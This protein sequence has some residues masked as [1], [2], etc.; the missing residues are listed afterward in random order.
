MSVSDRIQ[1][2]SPAKLELLRQRL[3]Q[4]KGAAAQEQIIPRRSDPQ[5]LVPLSFAQQRL[6]FLDGLNPESA[7]YNMP[8]AI[9]LRGELNV[10]ALERS[11]N[12]LLRRHE[13]LRTS[14]SVVD[15]EAV[16]VIAASVELELSKTDLTHLAANEAEAEARRLATAASQ[17]PFD[18]R[19]A[20]L[21]RA[22]L[23]RLSTEHHVLLLNLHHI[24]TDGWSRSV[25]YR[26]LAALYRAFNEGQEPQ[27][28]PLPIQYADFAVWQRNL[29]KGEVLEGHVNYWREQLAG[30]APTINLPTDHPRPA[31]ESFRGA[32][33]SVQ[34][35]ATLSQSLQELSQQEG[36]TLFMTL[37]AAWTVLLSRW[38]GEEEVIV[39]SPIANRT[40]AELEG[41]IGFFVNSLVLRTSIKGN[42]SFKELL[43]RVRETTLS[44]YAHQDLPFEKI[45]EVVQ[46]ERELSHNP[47]FQV[48]FALQNAPQGA[49]SVGGLEMSV[50]ETTRATARFDLEFHL[51]ERAQGLSGLLIYSTEL[52]EAETIQR[53]LGHF[54]TIL[55]SMVADPEQR[56][57]ECELMPAAE[58]EQLLFDGT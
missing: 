49:V 41:L 23:M 2:L 43:R 1:N 11:L 6:W 33:R 17:R 8:T 35:P 42:P 54:Q 36:V 45:V 28:V 3:Q 27:L 32:T 58:R 12:E 44:A 7:F 38:S 51:W 48:S 22:S 13:A 14:F 55:E 25:L 37:L 29:L 15:G 46:P 50:V 31:V 20:P 24:V 53:M 52:F 47:L 30:A 56:V 18:L 34:L 39:G 9:R 4:K 26:E 57:S 5:A 16:Q 21:M 19:R 10:S 40:R